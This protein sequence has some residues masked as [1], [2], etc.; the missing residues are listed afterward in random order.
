M[1][2]SKYKI[3]EEKKEK[4]KKFKECQVNLNVNFYQIVLYSVKKTLTVY[5]LKISLCYLH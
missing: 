1:W 3:L 4:E 5:P 2:K